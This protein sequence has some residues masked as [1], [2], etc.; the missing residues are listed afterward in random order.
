[1]AMLPDAISADSGSISAEDAATTPCASA[2]AYLLRCVAL[3][4]Y[5]KDSPEIVNAKINEYFSVVVEV[6]AYFDVLRRA[7][8]H[9]SRQHLPSLG[10]AMSAVC[11]RFAS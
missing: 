8:S 3:H 5:G 2:S 7:P 9:I 6:C 10:L 11:F 1:M 4:R